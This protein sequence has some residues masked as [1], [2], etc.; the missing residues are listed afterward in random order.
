MSQDVVSRQMAE[1]LEAAGFPQDT[2]YWWVYRGGWRVVLKHELSRDEEGLALAAPSGLEI[3][4][5]TLV[6]SDR[7]F[8]SS[9]FTAEEVGEHWLKTQDER[10]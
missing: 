1:A 10:H 4:L 6:H 3:M 7:V 2:C 9:F 5:L 8:I